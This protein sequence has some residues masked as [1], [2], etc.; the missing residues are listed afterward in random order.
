MRRK[1]GFSLVEVLIAMGVLSIGLLGVISTFT[2]G[3]QSQG[4]AQQMS[5][6]VNRAREI[7]DVIRQENWAFNPPAGTTWTSATGW[8]SST[9]TPL[10]AAPFDSTTG[11]DALP[12]NTNL[13]RNVHV[14]QNS[15]GQLATI[16]VQVFWSVRGSEHSVELVALQASATP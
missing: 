9:R 3:T 13:T 4:H 2:Y 12:A 1:L 11:V 6:A 10:D 15:S 16:T 14:T 8:A 5:Q 7:M